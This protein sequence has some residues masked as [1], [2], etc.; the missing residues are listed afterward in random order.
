MHHRQL[1]D[2]I[3]EGARDAIV[4]ALSVDLAITVDCAFVTRAVNPFPS[5]LIMRQVRNINWSY[6]SYNTAT[7]RI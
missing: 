4:P 3:S 6:F 2:E 1:V 7:Y 5:Q